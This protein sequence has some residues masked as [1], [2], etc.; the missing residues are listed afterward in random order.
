MLTSKTIFTSGLRWLWL[1]LL[2]LVIDL[3]IKQAITTCFMLYETRR[4]IP[5]FNL[6]YTHNPGAAFNFLAGADGWQRWFFAL[7]AIVIILL[8]LVLMYRSHASQKLSNIAYAL[9]IGGAAGNL[10]DRLWHGFVIDMIDF[11]IGNWHFPTFNIADSAICIGAA[12][13]VIDSFLPER[14]HTSVASSAS[15]SSIN[16]T[17]KGD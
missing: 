4:L 10:I 7:I 9:I 13:V 16:G 8:L 3:V 1:A 12:L 11:Y 17:E 14:I 15:P 2:V 6:H 5:F